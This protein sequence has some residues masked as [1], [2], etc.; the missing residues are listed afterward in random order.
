MTELYLVRHGQ[1]TR[2]TWGE[3]QNGRPLTPL[4]Q[5]QARQRGAWLRERGPFDA[6][7]CSPFQRAHDTARIIGAAVGREPRVVAALAEWQPP[8]YTLPVRWLVELFLGPSSRGWVRDSRVGQR[9]RAD[10]QLGRAVRRTSPAWGG[11]QR[12]VGRATAALA[13]QHPGGRLI[14]VSHGGTIR[15]TLA[16][17]GV[18]PPRL[19]H[20]DAVGLCS[21]SVLHLPGGDRPPVVASFDDC[22]TISHSRPNY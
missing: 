15:A 7:Y 11:F 10:S 17:F 1:P 14:L 22:A 4:G 18:P 6:L 5:E 12:R 3:S 13:A 9:L 21:V 16:Y 8:S 19:Y 20:M 2:I